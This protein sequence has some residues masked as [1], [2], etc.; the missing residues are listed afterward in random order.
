MSNEERGFEWMDKAEKRLK[1]FSL[2]SG[3]NAKFED[4]ADY[5]VKAANLFKVAKKW[6]LAADGFLKAAECQL[7]TSSKHEAATNYINAANCYK[8]TNPNDRIKY[9]KAAV[10]L[11]TDEGRFS[12]AAKQLKEIAEFLESE[13]EFEKAIDEFQQAADFFEGEGSTSQANQCLLKVAHLSAH[14]ERYDK[15]VELFENVARTSL[16]NN[17]LKW[18]V[19]EYFLKSILCQLASDDTV[20][21]KKALEKYQEWDVSFSSQREC[22]FLEEIIGAVEN[23]DVDAFTQ[24]VV[25]YDSISKLDQWKTSILLKIKKA[26][27]TDEETGGGLA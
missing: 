7:K 24:A 4:A 22:K 3:G 10:E 13:M 6:D 1:S 11:F 21:A 9:L 2:F 12:I 8:K 18:G 19:K 27:K 16:E 17:L 26:I 14:L 5:Y 23:L 20:S 15:A 25:E